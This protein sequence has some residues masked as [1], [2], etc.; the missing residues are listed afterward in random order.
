MADNEITIYPYSVRPYD[1]ARP[2][3]QVL[4]QIA[5][6][7]LQDRNRTIK[8]VEIRTEDIQHH[9][10]GLWLM[11]FVLLRYEGPGR[12]AYDRPTRD[13]QM[14]EHE[15]FSEETAALYD[16]GSGHLLVQYNH[17]GVRA[18]RMVDY[19]GTYGGNNAD[20]YERQVI[21]DHD[22]AAKLRSMR[23]FR[24]INVAVDPGAITDADREHGL[25]LGDTVR[26][27]DRYG[28][29]YIELTLSARYARGPNG[30]SN[31]VRDLIERLKGHVDRG[32]DDVQKLKVRG[33]EAPDEPAETLDLVAER[34]RQSVEIPLGQG[35]RYPRE[36]RYR[37]LRGV[38]DEWRHELQ[39]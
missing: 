22:V 27:H 11:D 23:I 12:A 14:G 17:R 16:P 30:L 24:K 8:G 20:A 19:F 34:K 10:G 38:W 2:L 1:R 37:A 36:A 31:R 9:D 25:G 21:Y 7:Q 32:E 15:R 4:G 28:G 35:R 33:T 29:N 13:F 6:D 5:R 26:L 39:R 3:E 18:G